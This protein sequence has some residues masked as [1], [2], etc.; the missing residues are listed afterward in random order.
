VR[1]DGSRVPLDAMLKP[2]HDASGRI[3]AITALVCV[4]EVAPTAKAV[5]RP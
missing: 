3:V 5:G 1:R 2:M 4:Q